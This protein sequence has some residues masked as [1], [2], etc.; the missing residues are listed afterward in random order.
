MPTRQHFDQELNELRQNILDLAGLVKERIDL[1]VESL[2][3]QDIELADKIIVGDLEVNEIQANLEEKC[4][5]II[6]TQQ[7]FASDLRRV[8]ASFK[9]SINLERMGDLAVNIAKITTRIGT[10][11]HIKPLIDIPEMKNLVLAMIDQ[12]LKA[13]VQEDAQLAREMSE[14]DD[15]IDH[16]Y[17][18]VFRE[19]LLIMMEKPQAINQANH[20]L[21]AARY[22]ERMGDYCTNLAEEI[23]YLVTA[24]RTDFNE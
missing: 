4:I 24:K 17:K 10:E 9:I 22:M 7:P 8:V 2:V 13:Y 20:L 6:A 21:F 23:F 16:L 11:R 19:L 18:E 3:N 14:I 1:A 15:Q 12:G 5:L